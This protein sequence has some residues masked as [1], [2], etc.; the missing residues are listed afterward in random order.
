MSRSRYRDTPVIGNHH[1][2]TWARPNVR[3]LGYRQ[4]D[5]LDGV[6]TFEYTFQ[7]G[8]RLD[9]LAAKFLGEDQYWWVLALVNGISYPFASGG[10]VPGRVL[11]IPVDPSD[12]FRKIFK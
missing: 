8:D 10:L 1:Y 3:A 5:L 12:V 6:K 7:V 2:T 9:V 11:R 4:T